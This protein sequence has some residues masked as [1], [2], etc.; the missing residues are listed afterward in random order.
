MKSRLT[1]G[2][3]MLFYTLG[4]L[5]MKG[6]SLLMLPV[7]THY[8]SPTEY[9]MLDAL[10]TWLNVLGIILGLGLSEALYRFTAQQPQPLLLYQQLLQL[11]LWVMLPI[12]LTLAL[13]VTVLPGLLPTALQLPLLQVTIVIA[14]LASATTLPLCWLR[15][16]DR[17]DWFFYCTAGKALLQS[18][19]CWIFL[20]L[21]YGL[22]GVLAASL[23]SHFVL[24]ALLAN[25]ASALRQI[26]RF[27]QFQR[28]S[29]CYGLP[30]VLSGLCLFLLYGAER[31]IIAGV[32]S[33]AVLAQYAVASQFA[34]MVA[35]CIEPFTLW[36]FPKRLQMFQQADGLKQ[37]ANSAVLGCLLTM[38]AAVC[39]GALGPLVIYRLLP[40]SYHQAA[41]ILPL[42]C[43]AMALKQC[44][45]LLNTG[46][47]V[48]HSTTPVAKINAYLAVVSPALY[49]IGCVLAGLAGL[50][51]ALVLVYFGRLVWFY[52]ASQALLT[53]PY[54][55]HRLALAL[56]P[57][58]A[59][60]ATPIV[61][62]LWLILVGTALAVIW[63]A[64]LALTLL[65]SKPQRLLGV[66]G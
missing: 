32:L 29:L 33:T 61:L 21:G 45:H 16:Q 65:P 2:R 8:L 62:P 50:L 28:Q 7:I 24:L 4:L 36:W 60:L 48:G 38:V 26:P 44:S 52:R 59:L 58:A 66:A 43:L 56:L 22:A 13:V 9:G 40:E 27:D 30:L 41:D 17:A 39:I 64:L 35:V 51:F 63:S 47:Y 19:C 49:L 53:L 42:L 10:L 11:H 5:L 6:V 14:A 1:V 3:Q 18:L 15:L 46:C 34:L 57:S 54:P 20:E 31:W 12:V 55:V 37:V 25:E 23:L